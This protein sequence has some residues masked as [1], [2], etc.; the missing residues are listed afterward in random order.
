MAFSVGRGAEG[1]K[2]FMHDPLYRNSFFMLINKGLGATTGF[3][4][5]IIAARFYQIGE[6]GIATALISGSMLLVSFSTFGFEITL[7]KFLRSYD[8]SRAFYT[9]LFVTMSTS[10]ALSVFYVLFV[11][12][13]SPYLSFIQQP[14]YAIVFILFTVVSSIRVITSNAFIALR[15]ARY[16]F[17]QNVLLLSSLVALVPL[18]FLGSLGIIGANF[19]SYITTYLIIFLIMLRF[20]PFKP[21]LD[22][23]FIKKSFRFSFGN[24]VSNIMYGAG[25]LVMPI[26]VL[27]LLGEDTAGVFYIAFSIGNFLLQ[28]PIALGVS[29]FVE[30]VYGENLRKNL[31]KSGTAMVS[32]LVPGI[33][34]FWVF[35]SSILALIGSS[36]VNDDAVNLLRLVALSSPLYAVYSLFQ[37]LLNIRM[38][39][40]AL[41][42]LNALIMVLLASLSYLF[43]INLGMTGVGYAM[44]ATFL[45]VDTVIIY[46]GLRWGW[47]SFHL[48]KEAIA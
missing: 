39:I 24:Y 34:L 29:F 41:I 7:V 38:K 45:I 3:I 12:Y 33:I 10:L 22:R 40:R 46:L 26:I 5:W 1:L 28:V 13:F 21:Q 11:N 18:S 4:F 37:P 47:L 32:L 8:R 20:I 27:N 36:Y 43:I 9:C 30:G 48:K 23:E 14:L 31:V 6:I 35:G 2:G 15:D 16:S 19:F 17:L 44:I 25:F 42:A